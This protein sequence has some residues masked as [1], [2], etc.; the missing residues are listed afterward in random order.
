MNKFKVGQKVMI[1]KTG[2][3]GRIMQIHGEDFD[4]DGATSL[5][6]GVKLDDNNLNKLYTVHDL[7]ETEDT[8]TAKEREYLSNII[9][10]FRSRVTDIEK[11]NSFVRTIE[12][13]SIHIEDETPINLP[14]FEKNTLYK[15]METHVHYTLE[16]LGL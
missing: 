12:Y 16:E 5:V 7:E 13:I 9:K 1:I 14:E 8:L 4:N 2:K 6:Y 10:P 11:C 15:N 3:L